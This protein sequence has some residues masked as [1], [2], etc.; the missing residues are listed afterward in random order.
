MPQINPLYNAI[1]FGTILSALDRIGVSLPI[2]ARQTSEL[3]TPILRDLTK[4]FLGDKKVPESL[5]EVKVLAKEVLE[6]DKVAEKV[7]LDVSKNP[8]EMKIDGCMYLD[9]A[10]FSKS[11]G[12]SACPTCLFALMTTS[13]ISALKLGRVSEATFK[14]NG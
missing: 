9:I 11:L 10:N 4:I 13:F 5:N 2:V 3:L 1:C 14:N 12:Y 8:I 6:R 7:E